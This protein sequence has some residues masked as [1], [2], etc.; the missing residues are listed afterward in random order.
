MGCSSRTCDFGA[1]ICD[2][3]HILSRREASGGLRSLQ[4]RYIFHLSGFSYFFIFLLP[5]DIWDNSVLGG[6]GRQ[7]TEFSKASS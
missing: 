6:R 1:G 2:G 7:I 3:Y 5:A 4:C